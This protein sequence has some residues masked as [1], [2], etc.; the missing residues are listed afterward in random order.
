[1]RI[2]IAL[3]AL[4]AVLTAG[5]DA[6]TAPSEQLQRQGREAVVLFGQSCA[7]NGGDGTKVA[8]WAQMHQARAL[9]AD[10]IKKLPLGMVE[11]DARFVWRIQK[12]GADYYL[13]LTPNSCSVKAAMADENTVRQQFE[14]L[15][16][17]GAQ[18]ANVELRA[19]NA[20]QSPFPFRQLSYAWRPAGSGSETVLT[21]NTSTSD[22]LPVQAALMLTHQTYHSVQILEKN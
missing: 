2:I 3:A 7:D 8:A 5:C 15:V 13:V 19:D 12:D 14:E 20:A 11:P 18:G 4:S 9:A 1:M 21:A 22:R 10:E 17:R 6:D 16:R